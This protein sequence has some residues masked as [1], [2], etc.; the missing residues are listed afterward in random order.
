MMAG[1]KI[2]A[3]LALPEIIAALLLAACGSGTLSAPPSASPAAAATSDLAGPSSSAIATP[4]SALIDADLSA[5]LAYARPAVSSV[6]FTDWS[7]L[8]GIRPDPQ[9][10]QAALVELSKDHAIPA[11]G[12]AAYAATT[13]QEWGFGAGDL[14]WQ[15]DFGTQAAPFVVLQFRESFD[16][17]SLGPLMDGRAYDKGA[18]V[19]GVQAYAHALDPSKPFII[20]GP[21]FMTNLGLDVVRHRL[22][23]AA[24]A[25][26]LTAA[27]QAR[28][29]EQAAA[30]PGARAVA[31]AAALG[32]PY[33]AVFSLE[34]G[35]CRTFAGWRSPAPSSPTIAPGLSDLGATEGTAL[36]FSEPSPSHPEVTI[37]LLF[38]DAA[39]AT[40]DLAPR[41]AYAAQAIAQDGQPYASTV[42]TLANGHTAGALLVFDGTASGPVSRVLAAFWRRDL[43]FA[44][45]P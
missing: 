26:A 27:I 36:A 13:R 33:A 40:A 1:V 41:S 29:V 31:L 12:L 7:R 25:D 21:Q 17:A 34:P 37:A 22:V 5:A 44:A 45:C 3:G 10:E 42:L 24:S 20:R 30:S 6:Y 19:D 43:P 14:A 38:A 15:A 8:F 28:T 9:T 39:K 35:A 4:A 18:I 11:S 23:I 2:R 16:I 32:S